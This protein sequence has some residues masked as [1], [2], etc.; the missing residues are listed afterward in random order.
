MTSLCN[1]RPGPQLALSQFTLPRLTAADY[2]RAYAPAGNG[3]HK[4]TFLE[5]F[6][7][8]ARDDI[9]DTLSTIFRE[10]TPIADD[11]RSTD[12]VTAPGITMGEAKEKLLT[13]LPWIR[14][15]YPDGPHETTLRHLMS[16]PH[17]G[18]TSAISYSGQVR[19]KLALGQNNKRSDSPFARVCFLLHYVEAE[20]VVTCRPMFLMR[21]A[22]TARS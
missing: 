13:K 12:V 14:I 15:K 3:G 21:I 6:P 20:N 17:T 10:A 16:A 7:P 18:R 11:H 8:F 22:G 9:V 19:V 4:P 1:S 2:V 5:H